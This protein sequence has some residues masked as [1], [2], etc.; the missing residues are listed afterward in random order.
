MSS[1][2]AWTDE[3]TAALRTL[4]RLGLTQPEIAK[5]LGRSF[6]SVKSKLYHMAGQSP[7]GQPSLAK[8]GNAGSDHSISARIR[9]DEHKHL[10]MILEAHGA[11]FPVCGRSA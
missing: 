4:D 1:G 7:E 8:G 6:F 2:N 5:R 9:V 11:G 10:S 3:E